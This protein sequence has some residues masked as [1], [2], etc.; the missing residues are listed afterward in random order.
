MAAHEWI[1][2]GYF[3]GLT[4]A[5][6]LKPGHSARRRQATAVAS[7]IVAMVLGLAATDLR[8]LRAWIPVVYLPAGYWLPA[9]LV[10]STGQTEFEMWLSRSDTMLRERLPPMP[11]MAVPFLEVA[12]LLC[13]PLVPLA[14]LV[15]WISGGEADVEHFWVAVLLSGYACY[16]TLPWLVSR[17][18]R[19]RRKIDTEGGLR[20]LNARVLERWS[21]QFN[22]FPS[23]HVA[24]AVAA[25]SSVGSVSTEAGAVIGAV[26]AAIAIG[27][28]A[29]GYHYIVDV[30]LGLIVAALAL[31]LAGVL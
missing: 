18:P 25:A 26:A 28:A 2:V 12:Y 3:F 24:V 10:T 11:R 16:V 13:Y 4:L 5:A 6:W 7:A 21:H 31:L 19:T 27:A 29:G 9:L 30:I 22:T 14:F 8:D 20:R 15:V 17:P 1:V 23:G